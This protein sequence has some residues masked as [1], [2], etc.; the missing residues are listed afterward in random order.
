MGLERNRTS[1]SGLLLSGQNTGKKVRMKKKDWA[2][3]FPFLSVNEKYEISVLGSLSKFIHLS[4]LGSLS[5]FIEI[6]VLGSLSKFIELSVLG[7]LSK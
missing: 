1:G 4:V 6:S 7:S 2:V 5:K 3:F